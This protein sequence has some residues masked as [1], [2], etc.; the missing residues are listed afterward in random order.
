MCS[1][2]RWD[3][4]KTHFEYFNLFNSQFFLNIKKRF[5]Y[6]ITFH[7]HCTF[8]RILKAMNSILSKTKKKIAGL[9]LQWVYF[10]HW[11][12]C[13]LSISWNFRYSVIWFDAPLLFIHSD[14][15]QCND[16]NYDSLV[17]LFTRETEQKK[18]TI[19]D[20]KS[21]KSGGSEHRHLKP[22]SIFTFGLFMFH[23]NK[24]SFGYEQWVI[25]YFF[26][27]FDELCFKQYFDEH[28]EYSMVSLKSYMMKQTIV[29]IVLA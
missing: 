26:F 2:W 6:F 10:I 29:D 18:Q 5:N 8:T 14:L 12:H 19:E 13:R 17:Q 23:C 11:S 24:T 3:H 22:V 25:N 4:T 27:V 28:T 9:S 15:F 1:I 21:N 16:R 7:A 20:K